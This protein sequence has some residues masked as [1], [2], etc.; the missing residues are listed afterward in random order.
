MQHGRQLYREE[1]SQTMRY[2]SNKNVQ[3]HRVGTE[4][5]KGALQTSTHFFLIKINHL[6]LQ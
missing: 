4:N 5:I 2:E 1:I 3:T 6:K